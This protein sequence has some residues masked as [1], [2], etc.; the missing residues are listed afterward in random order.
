MLLGDR[1][2]ISRFSLVFAVVLAIQLKLPYAG[3]CQ[4]STP[5]HATGS[6]LQDVRP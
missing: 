6:Y 3:S 4:A 2:S 5:F 1:C